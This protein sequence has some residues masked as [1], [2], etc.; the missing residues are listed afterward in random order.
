MKSIFDKMCP[1]DI[2]LQLGCAQMEGSASYH[3]FDDPAYNTMNA[4]NLEVFRSRGFP[5]LLLTEV[6][7][8]LRL[9]TILE[10]HLPAGEKIT[11][12]SVDVESFDFEV[13]KSNN[14]DRFE[15]ELVIVEDSSGFQNQMTP[16]GE[17][18]ITKGYR[19]ISRTR[20]NS[21]WSSKH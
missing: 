5:R 16:L 20:N 17:F 4:E 1:R 2:N 14:W 10:K 12:L 3:S 15:P 8:V 6:V 18:L 11:F 13:L 21:I 9:E 7:P 19:P